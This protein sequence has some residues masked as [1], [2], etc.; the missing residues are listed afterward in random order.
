V[1]LLILSSTRFIVITGLKSYDALIA[2]VV[3]LL[4]AVVIPTS[5]TTG[6][7]ESPSGNVTGMMHF[8]S[9]LA[10]F[11]H[12][13][14]LQCI[15][16]YVVKIYLNF[17]RMQTGYLIA[18]RLFRKHSGYKSSKWTRQLGFGDRIYG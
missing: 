1:S 7:V 16:F 3:F 18:G 8:Y 2:A 17:S 9:E 14:R 15:P 11:G 5:T 6:C 12:F 4:V 13:K 10:V